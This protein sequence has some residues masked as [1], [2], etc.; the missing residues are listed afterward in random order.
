MNLEAKSARLIA[1]IKRMLTTKPF[2][3]DDGTTKEDVDGIDFAYDS[4]S[5]VP[6]ACPLNTRTGYCGAG[7]TLDL[8]DAG[9][10]ES[11][12]ETEDAERRYIEWFMRC[13]AEGRTAAPGVRGFVSMHDS[14][15]RTDLDSGEE[16]REDEGKVKF[17][18][19]AS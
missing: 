8:L 13:W 6:I 19:D 16:F 17:F 1:E 14:S 2:L 11:F 10:D 18:N 12:P 9:E 5:W 7:E 4:D 15:W 3:L